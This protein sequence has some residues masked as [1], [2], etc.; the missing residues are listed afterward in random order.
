MR[1]QNNSNKLNDPYASVESTLSIFGEKVT[2]FGNSVNSQ[3][4]VS[5]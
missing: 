3:F 4:H 5:P 2:L 1:Q